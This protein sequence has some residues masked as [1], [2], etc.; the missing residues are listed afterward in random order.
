MTWTRS[1]RENLV[2][3]GGVVTVTV[4]LCVAVP[5]VPVQTR[6]YV[7]VTVGET[8]CVPDIAFVPVHP[9]DAV[10]DVAFVELH[11]KVEAELEL[12]SRDTDIVRSIGRDCDRCSGNRSSGSWSG[13]RNG[14]R[15][16]VGG[17]WGAA[18]ES[19]LGAGDRG[20]GSDM[21]VIFVAKGGLS[22]R[23]TTIILARSNVTKAVRV[24]IIIKRH[25]IVTIS[26]TTYREI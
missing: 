20:S 10:Q 18:G 2:E 7:M 17:G 13:Q 26:S 9:A 5:P 16:G 8:D 6:V 4:A 1:L 12:N 3:G 24:G 11:V 19:N 21:D 23:H 15:S 22:G 14:G 25:S